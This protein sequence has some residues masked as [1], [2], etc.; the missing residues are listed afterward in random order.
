MINN[1]VPLF[2]YS[3]IAPS[4]FNEDCEDHLS[5]D[6][7]ALDGLEAAV[8]AF[9]KEAIREWIN[10]WTARRKPT[11]FNSSVRRY[12]GKYDLLSV[13]EKFADEL[14]DFVNK[15]HDDNMPTQLRIEQAHENGECKE[16]DR[17]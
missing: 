1:V 14:E 8:L 15:F 7:L 2:K 11:P 16:V 10:L 17:A 6:L 3:A 12:L 4:P 5:G 13:A 9:P